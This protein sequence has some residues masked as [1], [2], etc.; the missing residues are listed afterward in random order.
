MRYPKISFFPIG[1]IKCT[2]LSKSVNCTNEYLKICPIFLSTQCINRKTILLLFI[3]YVIFIYTPGSTHYPLIYILSHFKNRK[4]IL[5]YEYVQNVN[6][7]RI[8]RLMYDPY[9]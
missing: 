5:D 9:L 1:I 6:I 2:I 7:N 8:K 3:S 4:M